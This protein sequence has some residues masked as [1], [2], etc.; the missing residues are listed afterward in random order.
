MVVRGTVNH[1]AAGGIINCMKSE[2]SGWLC[3]VVIALATMITFFMSSCDGPVMP[4]PTSNPAATDTPTTSYPAPTLT[5]PADGET[6]RGEKWTNFSWH[7]DGIL[8]ERERFD[9]RIWRSGK[10]CRSIAIP[11]EYDFSLYTPP[12]GFGQYLWQ[13]AVFRVDENGSK[14]ILSESLVRSFDWSDVTPA[15]PDTPTLTETPLL[16]RS[17]T[18]TATHTPTPAATHTSIP[19]PT[20][21]STP[22]ATDTPTPT[23]TPTITLTP[24]P[25]LLPAPTLLEPKDGVK[26]CPA[27]EIT[28]KWEWNV[29]PF[30]ANEYYAVRIWK[31]EPGRHERSR[32]W[33][34]D[35]NATT[36][37]TKL[38]GK[39]E[40][41][42]GTGWY[43]WNVVVLFD[44]GQVDEDGYK[45]WKP[46][47]ETSESRHFFVRKGDDPD[48]WP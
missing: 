37:Q 5:S 15:P 8:Q 12:D 34:P 16:A 29:R 30:Q 32:H 43:L 1:T 47:S 9:V 41:F 25:S 31:D 35:Y 19:T 28:L 44:T 22:T 13:V 33:E 38:I 4:T 45:I 7:W 27:T 42:E 14:L 18:P 20:D 46:M 23:C 2:K 17:P 6:F 39:T 26:Y 36:Y 11:R 48:C 40:W 3:F 10:P 21:T 24:T